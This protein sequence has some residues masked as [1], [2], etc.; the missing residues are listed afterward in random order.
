MWIKRVEIAGFGKFQQQQFDFGDG[1]QVVYGLNE[2]GKS[3]LRAFILGMLFDFPSRRHQLERY[4]PQA[5]SQYGG[6]LDLVVDETPYRLTRLSEQPAT[7]I[8]LTNQASQPLSLLDKWL[9]PYDRSQYLQLFTFNQAE[10]TALKTLRASDLNMQLQ[11]AGL[12]GSAPWRD[13]ATALRKNADELYKPRGRKPELN[14][15]LQRYHA[16][17]EQVKTAKQRYPEYVSL[18]DRLQGL[19]AEQA[20]Q[21]REEER[22][23]TEQQRLANLRNQWPLYQQLQQLQSGSADDHTDQLSEATI[24]QY[25]TLTT[26]QTELQHALASARE[27]LSQQPV[28][29]QS[30]GLIGF[31]VQHQDQFEQLEQQ[32][33]TLQ[34]A[35]GKHQTLTQQV[36]EAKADYQAQ[37]NAHPELLSCL[38]PHKR[39]AI[40]DLKQALTNVPTSRG[41]QQSANE[42]H[43]DWRLVAGGV[44]LVAGLFLPLGAFKWL[45][46]LAGCGLLGWFGWEELSGTATTAEN[47]FQEQLVAAG[48]APNLTASEALQ[49]L[50]LVAALQRAQNT[51]TSAEQ[52]AAA[53]AM[54]VWQQ[55]QAYQFAAGWIPVDEQHLTTSVTRVAQFYEQV[56]QNMQQQT[57]TG[58]DFAFT[59]RQVQ[60]LTQQVHEL[61]EQLQQLAAANGL[62]DADGL[63]RAIETYAAQVANTASAQQLQQQLSSTDL[64]AL[65]AYATL[66]DLQA[67]IT[68]GRNQQ[69]VVQQA[70]TD[71]T[72]DLVTTQAQL[73]QLTEDGR[74]AILRQQQA[75]M[76]TEITVLARQ[77]MTRQLGANWIDQ[78]LQ[79]LTQQQLPQVL[80]Q[81]A[82]IF[83]Q[84]TGKRYNEIKLADE[85]LLAIT[86]TGARFNVAE[87]STAT[88]EQLYLALRLALINHLGDQARLPLM[89]DDGFVNFDEH[90]RQ[91]AWQELAE[92]AQ[93]HQVIY[94]TNETA[95]LTQLPT[96]TVQQLT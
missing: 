48:L 45:L 53:Q 90:R 19:Q 1:L 31:Y 64:A 82:V 27:Q 78:A 54:V 18:Q 91:A 44:G 22:L 63:A 13:T 56:R 7:L 95:A 49:Q 23:N 59:Q 71:Q 5:T 83:A 76:Q 3:T 60:Q 57:M 93:Q 94:F 34:Q 66:A 62:A 69:A 79:L 33:P 21:Q 15:A 10:L 80:A 46:I 52:Q 17:S 38:S 42:H 88:K 25:Q 4:E 61:T 40:V 14:Q 2:S 86:T 87:L 72:A 55:L 16:L 43:V 35:L 73:K 37:S 96:A 28:D 65:Q 75:N 29:P 32:L 92:V 84:L 58:P 30:Q 9:A 50:E 11:Q 20:R 81:A 89:I 39:D 68:T 12:V 74:Y 36:T 85:E 8:N 70:L 77:W 51:V 26:K 67:A 47:E 6:S 24:Q 41:Q